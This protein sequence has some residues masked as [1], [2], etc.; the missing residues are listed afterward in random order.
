MRVS[1]ETNE[2][3]HPRRACIAGAMAALVFS[4]LSLLLASC[5]GQLEAAVRSDGSVRAE[6]SLSVPSALGSRVRQFAGIPASEALFN[7]ELVR[8][9]FAERKG[10]SLLSISAPSGESLNSVIQVS[11]LAA[12]VADTKTVPE[13]MI[14]YRYIPP[15]NALAAM[16]ELTVRIDR[17]N[18]AYMLKLFP[19]VNRKIIDSLSPPALEPDPVSAAEYRLNLEQVIIGPK[20]MPAFD[21]CMVELKISTPK[22]IVIV[23]GGTFSGQVFRVKIPLFDLLTL[24]K[25]V[26]FS[27]R[28]ID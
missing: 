11:D 9:E 13:G 18:A 16:R 7:P 12:L 19:G 10:V 15:R 26:E 3:R 1:A 23:T 28:W 25:P 5:S 24:E 27:L 22:P 4:V 2:Q 21:A 8:K 17:T 20:N 6:I 14:Q